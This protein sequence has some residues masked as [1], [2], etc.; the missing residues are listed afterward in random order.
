MKEFSNDPSRN[1]AE[2]SAAFEGKI[3]QLQQNIQ[4][5]KQQIDRCPG[6]SDSSPPLFPFLPFPSLLSSRTTK[7]TKQYN[8]I[9]IGIPTP[10]PSPS[11][12][13][14]H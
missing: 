13:D 8:R 9:T 1:I 5:L 10:L 3:A 7:L 12:T 2:L 11:I 6:V 14:T 4:R